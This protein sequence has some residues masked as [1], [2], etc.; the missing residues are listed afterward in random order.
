MPK[1]Y[2]ITAQI[3]E[4]KKSFDMVSASED[5]NKNRIERE[6]FGKSVPK[7]YKIVKFVVIKEKLGI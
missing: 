5:F 2:R 1:Y 6:L 7:P 4:I 3:G